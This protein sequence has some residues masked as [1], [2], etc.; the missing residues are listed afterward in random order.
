MKTPEKDMAIKASHA[1]AYIEQQLPAFWLAER[2]AI[3]WQASRQHLELY[4]RPICMFLR[5][6]EG[7][8]ALRDAW[9]GAPDMDQFSDSDVECL[10]SA[11]RLAQSQRQLSGYANVPYGEI[12]PLEAIA[13]TLP[14]PEALLEYL[15]DPYP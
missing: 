5:E 13:R 14:N 10:D 6:R 2:Q 9:I 15:A 8:A 4:G 11:I 3:L 1:L 12:I 7:P